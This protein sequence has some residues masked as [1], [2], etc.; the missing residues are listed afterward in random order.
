MTMSEQSDPK[1]SSKRTISDRLDEVN[2]RPTGFDYMRI[3]LALAV[4]LAHSFY[5]NY[6]GAHAAEREG[7]LSKFTPLIVPMF[8]ALSGFLVAGS[9][10]RAK[11]LFV[12]FGLRVFRIVPA[13]TVEVLLSALILGP[14]L[15]EF[16]L[17]DYF[18]DTA[19]WA[20]FLNILGEIH[21]HLPGLFIHNPTTAV[22]GQL[23]TVPFELACYALLGALA[24]VNAYRRGWLLIAIFGALQALQIVNTIYRFNPNYNGAGGSTIVLCFAAGLLLY[25]YRKVIVYSAP[26]ALVAFVLSV[27][28]I[29]IP[30]AIRFAPLPM[31]YL[32]V[33]LG[34]RNPKLDRIVNSGDYSYGLYLYGYPVQQAVITLLPGMREWYWNLL[35]SLPIAAAIAALSWHLIEKPVLSRK[36]ILQRINDRIAAALVR[37]W[38]RMAKRE[39]IA[40]G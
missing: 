26:L 37:I 10:E 15:T 38:P 32:T 24:C 2:H 33:Y 40:D 31:A 25:R 9:L 3:G 39:V 22:N 8:F 1:R 29:E 13:L 17:S 14:L 18:R 19:F 20:Y 7:L 21:Y 35:I 5:L 11:S 12:F 6:G 23:W 36:K 4:I 28:S 27:I 30:N 34:L 16:P